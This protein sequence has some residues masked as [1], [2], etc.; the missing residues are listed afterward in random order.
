MAVPISDRNMPNIINRG[1]AVSSIVQADQKERIFEKRYFDVSQN[2][3]FQLINAE[4]KEVKK[5]GH[6]K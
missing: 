3:D 4:P 1:R 2:I 5:I 6:K